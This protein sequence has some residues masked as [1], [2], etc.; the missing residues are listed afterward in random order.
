MSQ[1]ASRTLSG[2]DHAQAEASTFAF[3]VCHS[4]TFWLR[5]TVPDVVATLRA[6]DDG[7]M[8]E[9]SAQVESSSVVEPAAMRASLLGA[10][11]FDTERHPEVSFRSTEVLLARDG[12]VELEGELTM[13][14]TTRPVTASGR[15]R[16]SP[17]DRLRRDR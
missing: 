9:G 3:P 14:G 13:R 11:F 2:T 1:L 10:E 8:L 6:D 17:A 7:L 15:V 12:R 5:G 4:E 16:R